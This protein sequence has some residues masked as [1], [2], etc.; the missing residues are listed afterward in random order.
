MLDRSTRARM[1]GLRSPPPLT[2]RSRCS[3]R[4]GDAELLRPR[5][6]AIVGPDDPDADRLFSFVD[7]V[8]TSEWLRQ[9]GGDYGLDAMAATPALHLT[10]E[11]V[12]SSMDHYELRDYV[13]GV[14]ADHPEASPDG[15]TIYLFFFPPSASYWSGCS[16]LLGAHTFLDSGGLDA[17][18]FAQRCTQDG[19]DDF[20]GLTMTASHGM[21]KRPPT[22]TSPT[23]SS[24]RTRL[25]RWSATPRPGP[26]RAGTTIRTARRRPTSA[27]ERATSRRLLLRTCVEQ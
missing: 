14:L 6:V 13:N 10:G 3:P 20:D 1:P 11:P 18:A 16:S 21:V 2:P 22:R 24:F 4:N 23:D 7:T 26:A 8:L 19:L 27:M 5:I 17:L 25:S 12:L 15:R 9:V